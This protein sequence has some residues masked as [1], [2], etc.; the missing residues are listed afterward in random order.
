MHQIQENDLQNLEVCSE[1]VSI[2]TEKVL[3]RQFLMITQS[4]W[5][6]NIMNMAKTIAY[7]QINNALHFDHT[8]IKI[9]STVNRKYEGLSDNS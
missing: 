3:I 5:S 8:Y 9:I 7:I 4:D 1:F 2:S 6:Q